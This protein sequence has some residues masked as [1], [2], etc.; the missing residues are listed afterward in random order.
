MNKIT[1]FIFASFVA[2][3]FALVP[4]TFANAQ[5]DQATDNLNK[6]VGSGSQTGLSSDLTGTV[7]TIVRGV[8][9]LTGTIFLLLTIYSGI[10]WMTAQGQEEQITK[11]QSIIKACII[12]LIVTLSAY[13]ITYFVTNRLSKAASPTAVAK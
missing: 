7:G 6:A 2:L 10:L 1:S 12:G 9:A 8:L 4:L 13:S 3:A 5:L 11:A